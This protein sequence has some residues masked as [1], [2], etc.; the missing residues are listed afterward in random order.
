MLNQATLDI[1]KPSRENEER[2]SILSLLNVSNK[3]DL[4]ADSGYLTQLLIGGQLIQAGH[5]FALAGPFNRPLPLPAYQVEFGDTKYAVRFGLE[6]IN[7]RATIKAFKEEHASLD[8]I[9]VNQPEMTASV[10]AILA[11]LGLH[12]TRIFVYIHY[13]PIQE[14]YGDAWTWDPSLNDGGLAKVIMHRIAEGCDIGDAI[15]IHAHFGKEMLIRVAEMIGYPI[16]PRKIHV[17]PTATDPYLIQ[18]AASLDARIEQRFICK[19]GGQRLFGYPNRLYAHYGTEEMFRF[20][21][22]ACQAFSAHTWVTN[23]TSN[24]SSSR[25][26][27]DPASNAIEQSVVA[28]PSVISFGKPL[29]RDV[30]KAWLDRSCFVFGPNRKA[31][32]WS[33]SIVDG[34]GMGVPSF[35]PD[36]GSFPELVPR[37]C[38]WRNF[39]E[40]HDKMKTVLDDEDT[41]VRLAREC[42]HRAVQYLPSNQAASLEK[43]FMD[44][45]SANDNKAFPRGA[46]N[47]P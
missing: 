28:S 42:H 17:I 1:D 44:V 39:D 45:R 32:L 8:W 16:D 36:A 25:R 29:P 37:E 46:V 22:G 41:Y 38:L 18:D 2:I 13:L 33:L 5:A 27:L 7:L 34:M 6:Y 23:P 9:W 4:S 14:F 10:R 21:D 24:K 47:V 30:Y 3:Q 43:I 26:A 19:D 40:L 15:G 20:F 35:A 12:E 11:E 31:A